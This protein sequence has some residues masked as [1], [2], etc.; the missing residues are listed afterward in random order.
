MDCTKLL[1]NYVREVLMC[2][3]K[4]NLNYYVKIT[5]GTALGGRKALTKLKEAV[6]DNSSTQ[7]MIGF[8]NTTYSSLEPYISQ[9]NIQA[10]ENIKVLI[11][12]TIKFLVEDAKNAEKLASSGVDNAETIKEF[13]KVNIERLKHVLATFS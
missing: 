7:K 3:E 1:K 6:Y 12:N 5:E 11:S 9:G 13:A 8:V 10:E 2:S 4:W